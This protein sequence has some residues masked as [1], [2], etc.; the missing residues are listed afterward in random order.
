MQRHRN[1]EANNNWQRNKPQIKYK[2]IYLCLFDENRNKA[3]NA[4]KNNVW[5]RGLKYVIWSVN[6]NRVFRNAFPR[7]LSVPGLLYLTNFILV[8]IAIPYY[9]RHI[10]IL[11]QISYSLN[12]QSNTTDF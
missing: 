11:P 3:Y 7:N 4:R 1:K 2:F 10:I 6:Q 12:A 5:D 9:L 8:F